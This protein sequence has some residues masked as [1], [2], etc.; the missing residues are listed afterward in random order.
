M[1]CML[2]L[3]T[4]VVNISNTLSVE[5]SRYYFATSFCFFFFILSVF[6]FFFFFFFLIIRRPPRSPLFPYTTLFRSVI[7]V[8]CIISGERHCLEIKVSII[9][10]E[11]LV[12]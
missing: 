7:C 8:G 9:Q 5:C 4:L 10:N 1:T 12:S 2:S 11:S 3:N 6:Y